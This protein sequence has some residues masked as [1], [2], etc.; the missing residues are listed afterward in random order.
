[1]ARSAFV[2]G[3]LFSLWVCIASAQDA[4]AP[5]GDAAEEPAA[6][7]RVANVQWNPKTTPEEIKQYK[8]KELLEFEPATKAQNLTDAQQ[9]TLTKFIRVA[10][11][12]LTVEQEV[13]NYPRIIEQKILA[14]IE[15]TTTSPAAKGWMRDEVLKAAEELLFNDTQ[16]PI[17]QYNVVKLVGELNETP[18]TVRPPAPA[19]PYG[20]SYKLLT[21]VLKDPKFPIHCRIFA[22]LGLE[23]I[24]RDGQLESYKKSEVGVDLATLL[25]EPIQDPVARKWLRMRLIDALGETGRVYDVGNNPVML[26]AL[27][28]VVADPQEEWD[29]RANAARRATQ[30]PFDGQTNVELINHEIGKLVYDVGTA[31][32]AAKDRK[33]SRWR[34]SFASCYLAYRSRTEQEQKV[35]HWGL[36][37]QQTT[38]GKPQVD[39]AFKIMLPIFKAQIE[40]DVAPNAAAA[41]PAV[42]EPQL[43]ALADWLSKNKPADRKPNTSSPQELKEVAPSKPDAANAASPEANTVD[44][45]KQKS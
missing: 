28:K 13:D 21:R 24:L 36:L 17:V 34:W 5:A 39:A 29:V 4:A 2:T 3:G 26:D 8:K 7:R 25:S 42:P 15:R 32:N 9:Q 16:P 14:P 31:Y 20:P 27:M 18:A 38:R 12:S 43:K 44:S 41:P 37:F 1:M 19:V 45:T 23:R 10:I 30:L 40:Y 6:P 11:Y 22:A 35:G 33:A